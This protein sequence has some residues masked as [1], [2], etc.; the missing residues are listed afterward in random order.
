[1]PPQRIREQ[2]FEPLHGL[3]FLELI[4]LLYWMSF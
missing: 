2:G 3:G 4:I 1:V